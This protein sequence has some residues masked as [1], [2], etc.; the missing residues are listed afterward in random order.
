MET[1]AAAPQTGI[2]VGECRPLMLRAEPLTNAIR[3][4]GESQ[5]FTCPNKLR[6]IPQRRR[7]V[8][9]P[10]IRPDAPMPPNGNLL[11]Q[12]RGPPSPA[13][14]D[15]EDP[16]RS[17]PVAPSMDSEPSSDSESS[18]RRVDGGTTS[19]RFSAGADSLHR[20][21]TFFHVPIMCWRAQ[22][23]PDQVA[24]IQRLADG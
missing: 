4:A 21:S 20:E 12:V 7:A 11:E 22:L 13:V 19:P 6:P 15:L 14:S 8:T 3:F 10:S 24:E 2:A 23:R 9:P 17:Q 5:K 18:E 16:L 1:K